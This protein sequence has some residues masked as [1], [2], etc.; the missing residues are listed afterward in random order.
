MGGGTGGSYSSPGGSLSSNIDKLSSKF[1]LDSKGRFGKP[2]RG[3]AQVVVSQD[4]KG[5]GKMFF[6]TLGSGG[7][8]KDLSNGKGKISTFPDKSTVV[9]RPVSSSDGSPAISIVLKGPKGSDYKIHFV[10]ERGRK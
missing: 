3:G 6:D 4:P 1:P 10:D 2:G 5:T 8:V 7:T 9:F